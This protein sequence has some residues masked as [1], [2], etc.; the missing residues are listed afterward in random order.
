MKITIITCPYDPHTSACDTSKLDQFCQ[1]YDILDYQGQLTVH[2]GIPLWTVLI[3]YRAPK[4]KYLPEKR[5]ART[6]K[7]DP[8][9][10]LSTEQ[11]PLYNA[12]RDWRRKQAEK[13]GKPVF[14]LLKNAQIADVVRK[15]P[16]SVKALKTVDG[17]GDATCTKYGASIISIIKQH[18]ERDHNDRTSSSP[19]SH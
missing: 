19:S 13:E 16:T 15:S 7:I 12:L 17:V 6:V 5:E 4:S 2:E 18:K 11:R 8:F 14:A 9:R 3:S 1:E 10:Q